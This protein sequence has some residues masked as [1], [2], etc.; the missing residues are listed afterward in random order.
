MR[1]T[2]GNNKKNQNKET[3]EVS[4]K[5]KSYKLQGRKTKTIKMTVIIMK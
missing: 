1:T 4:T 5:V 2:I 3:N